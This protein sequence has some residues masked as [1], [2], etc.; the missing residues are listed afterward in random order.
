METNR[1]RLI[2][3]PSLLPQMWLINAVLPI[4]ILNLCESLHR[5]EL[6]L[7]DGGEKVEN[8]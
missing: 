6:S 5:V 3:N 4:S 2:V 8:H 1:V 7:V